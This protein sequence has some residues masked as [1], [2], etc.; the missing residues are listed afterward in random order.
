[1]PGIGGRA[2]AEVPRR[3]LS[4]IVQPRMEEVF[5][6]VRER[7]EKMGHW[8]HV[9][10]GVVLTGGGALMQG[11]PELAQEMFQM[12]VRVGNP[13]TLGGL[14]EE[15]RSPLFATAVGLVLMGAEDSQPPEARGQRPP[16]RQGKT[17]NSDGSGTLGRLADWIRKG[18]F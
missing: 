15:Y 9:K 16:E 8:K 5:G 2:P 7:V 18:F 3:R 13:I 14:V 12:P 4:S 17:K 1:V 10:G 6:L 11:A